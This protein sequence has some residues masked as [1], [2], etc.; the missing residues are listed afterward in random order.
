ME[1]KNNVR[2][3][4]NSKS[5]FII[6][7]LNINGSNTSGEKRPRLAHFK[8]HDTTTCCLQETT[9]RLTTWLRNQNNVALASGKTDKPKEAN[10]VH[11]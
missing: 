9:Q 5:Y 10:L 3:E 6:F 4:N 7:S 11:K 1:H 2:H 8:D